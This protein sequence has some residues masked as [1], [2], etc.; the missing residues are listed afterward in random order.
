MDTALSTEVERFE[1]SPASG[2]LPYVM[3]TDKYGLNSE[4]FKAL[5]R[6]EVR[7]IR[8]AAFANGPSCELISRGQA[9]LGFEPYIN[10]SEV[11]KI[12]MA[13][14]ETEL[15]PEL[16]E[17]YFVVAREHL[18][19]FRKAC[20]P[21]GSPLDTLRGILDEIWP[22]G[23]N[24]QT[25]FGRK[26]F[27]GLSRMVEPN[28]TFL[29]HHDIFSED[30]PGIEEAESLLAQFAANIYFQVPEVGGEL[31]MWHRNMTTEEFD[32]RRR[33]KYGIAVEDLPTP[34]VIVKPGRGDLL[35]FDSRKIHAVAS[36]HDT[37]R[38]AVSF[39]IGYRGDDQP[40]T[41]WS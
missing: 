4:H 40:L 36:P 17:R 35:I 9:S 21:Y 26:M 23:A 31:L 24:L 27:V 30:A 12:G 1:A 13:F 32:R 37:A 25:L 11:R 6:G 16:I 22:A 39:F 2:G 5:A 20:E 8:V 33:G 38:M 15:K 3:H 14:Y 34:D 28:T 29:A 10:V 41:Y 19:D 18:N 7:V